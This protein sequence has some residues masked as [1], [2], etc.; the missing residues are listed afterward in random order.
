MKHIV[1]ISIIVIAIVCLISFGREVYHNS[2]AYKLEQQIKNAEKQ[3]FEARLY[4]WHKRQ[5]AQI[6]INGM[7]ECPELADSFVRNLRKLYNFDSAFDGVENSLR[8][9]EKIG[10]WETLARI[11][12]D[13]VAVYERQHCGECL[14]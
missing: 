9:A 11:L 5:D 14:E 6:I 4:C 7:L 1:N 3:L 13:C 8:I 2:D 12:W 10:N